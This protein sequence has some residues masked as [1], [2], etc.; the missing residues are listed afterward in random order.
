[1]KRI[2][3]LMTVAMLAFAE[4]VNAQSYR[5]WDF[6]K[7]SQQ[8]ID[9]LI[10]DDE[11][12]DETG[13][14]DVE[15]LSNMNAVD[16]RCFWYQDGDNY[17]TV[18]ANGVVISELEGLDF[19]QEY[20]ASRNLAIA[21][22][23]ASTSIGTY[24]GPQ[25]LWLGINNTPYAFR[26]P[27]VGIGQKMTFVVESHRSGQ[28]RGIGLYVSDENGEM[29]IIGDTFT[30]DAQESRTWDMWTLPEG[31][32]DPDGDGLVDIY[33]KPTSGCHIYLIEIGENTEA[34]TV[35][36]L[37]NGS[38]D[39]DLG[40]Q[41]LSGDYMNKVTAIEANKTFTMEDF[42]DYDAIAI[43]S[44]VDNAD[45]IASLKLVQPF[46]PILNLNPNLYAAWGYGE[47]VDAGI[48][49]ATTTNPNHALFRKLELIEDPDAEEP[50]FVLA[51][52]NEVP[53]QGL[54]LAGLFADDPVLAVAYQNEEIVAIHTHNL[55]HNGYIYIP[56]T[57]ETLADAATPDILGNALALLASSK[58]PVTQ[59]PAPTFTLEYENLATTVSIQDAAPLPEIFYTLD[60]SDPTEEST[61]YTEPFTVEQETTVKAIARGD[62]YL[63]SLVAEKLID[64]RQKAPLPTFA[65]EQEDG[66]TIVT[67][68]SELEGAKIYY[69]YKGD[70]TTQ[71][72]SPY[73]GPITITRGKTIYAF[74]TCEGYLDSKV[75]EAKVSVKNPHVRIDILAQMD[76]NQ[77]T[78]YERTNKSGGNVGYYFSWANTND[79]P[80]WDPEFDE[81]V[82]GSDGNDSIIHH[83]LNNEE[84][85]DFENG[86]S[87][88]SRGQRVSWEGANPELN[89]GDSGSGPCNPATVED[90]DTYL[91]VTP[92]IVNLF[93]W[94][95]QYPASAKIQTTQPIAGPF[96]YVAY[97]VNYKGSPYARLVVE[98]AT[99][100]EADD[101]GWKQVG[102][103]LVLNPTRRLYHM[104]V[105]SY[106]ET[107]PVYTRVR[108]VNNGPRAGF[109]NIYI[110]NEGEESKKLIQEQMDGI[111]EVEHS[112]SMPEGIYNISGSRQNE[113]RKGINIIVNADG[114]VRKVLVK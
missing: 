30:P 84:V 45:A 23:Y 9:N 49:F 42:A 106:E 71:K 79:H 73:N 94:D 110:T 64:I 102:D 15:Y 33:V 38:L 29:H 91:P 101:A 3:I 66:K 37:Y 16:K 63:M 7:F 65:M 32:T 104:F 44:T 5:R 36:Y 85:V 92:F 62:G 78:Y 48:Q 53:F 59:A 95:T 93:D 8:T 68:S 88:R 83:K 61:R 69:N 56:Y 75:A 12:G 18:K 17:G 6:T 67:I 14:S 72:S 57:Q 109:F 80:Y 2:F 20:C 105:R 10:A 1:M 11:Q 77:D 26:I 97:I 22:D 27:N 113:L 13:W 34:R 51:V 107:T 82:V 100:P 55:A 54:K 60:G 43:S 89:Y 39:A 114:N 86:W 99:D 25:Y 112:I 41:T 111:A 4:T 70:G 40:Y 58:A 28:G 87:V 103:T 90:E 108:T 24:A 76:A 81:T 52:S 31:V 96:D 74:Q 21:V 98:V 46:V 19:G 35:G 50:T 47:A